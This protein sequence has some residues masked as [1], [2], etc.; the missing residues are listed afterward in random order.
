[1]PFSVFV[2][3]AIVPVAITLIS[4]ALFSIGQ[5]KI[6]VLAKAESSFIYAA[7]ILIV[8]LCAQLG[9]A[10]WQSP[11]QDASQW[12]I[13]F[14]LGV[15]IL[16][17]AQR[18]I[19]HWLSGVIFILL[20]F[21]TI[22]LLLR[23][24]LAQNLS[25]GWVLLA[26]F[27]LSLNFASVWSLA[28][29]EHGSLLIAM[30]GIPMAVSS[31]AIIVAGNLTVGVFG[32]ALLA[33]MG[34]FF[35]YLLKDKNQQTL[36]YAAPISVSFSLIHLV[37]GH[38]YTDGISLV[39]LALLIFLFPILALIRLS[40]GTI[41]NAKL[42]YLSFFA[43][44]FIA[45]GLSSFLI[46]KPLLIVDQKEQRDPIFNGVNKTTNPTNL[47]KEKSEKKT[48]WDGDYGYGF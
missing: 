46:L 10:G 1:M 37:V 44:I 3:G 12:L 30:I 47:N 19:P 13:Y 29:D 34:I 25:F 41:R 15:L 23:P 26:G 27:A 4:L 40:I 14:A 43:I 7:I 48:N 16:L 9:F 21:A 42:N 38:F 28:R 5:R 31:A 35:F 33:A 20:S 6:S 22:Y 24:L 45:A 8:H 36:L 39:V 17:V 11:N 18:Y 2:W 32:L